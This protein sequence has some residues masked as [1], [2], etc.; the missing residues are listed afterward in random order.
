M[1][2]GFGSPPLLLGAAAIGSTMLSTGV[3]SQTVTPIETYYLPMGETALIQSMK[4]VNSRATSPLNS[5]Q[6]VTTVV[7]GTIVWYDHWEDGF[8]PDIVN[9]AQ[10][11]TLIIGDGDGS[12]GC[13]PAPGDNKIRLTCSND[14]ED[15]LP[16]GTAMILENYI[17]LPRVQ[18]DIYYDGGDRVQSSFPIAITRGVHSGPE[19]D[20]FPGALL[21]GAVET[22]N[23]KSWGKVFVAPVGTGIGSQDATSAY[24]LTDLYL[25]AAEDNTV[26]TTDDGSYDI[27]LPD[28]TA[29]TGVSGPKMY[30]INMGESLRISKTRV[31][32]RVVTDKPVQADLVTGD[33]GSNY[34]MRWCE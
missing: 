17:P 23:T 2:L 14:S 7:D 22:V 24:Q 32:D 19:G 11:S 33:I 12:N 1:R 27:T 8:E 6:S 15:T 4:A 18:G 26:V 9:P 29:L 3:T 30:T 34:E 31:G 5:M 10:D 16:P 28:G 21:G 13:A 20:G 25:Q